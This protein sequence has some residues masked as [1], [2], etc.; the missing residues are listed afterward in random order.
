MGGHRKANIKSG[1]KSRTRGDKHQVKKG[2]RKS[3]GKVQRKKGPRVTILGRGDDLQKQEY[4]VLYALHK[5]KAYEKGRAMNLDTILRNQ[6]LEKRKWI[7]FIE[8]FREMLN[9][10]SWGEIYSERRTNMIFLFIEKRE[11]IEFYLR[12]QEP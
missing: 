5:R 11:E 6:K 4:K 8:H 7:D 1:K 2:G 12:E 9:E 10:R 3:I